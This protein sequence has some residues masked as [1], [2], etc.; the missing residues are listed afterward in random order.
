MARAGIEDY[1]RQH[2]FVEVTPEIMSE[3]RGEM[4]M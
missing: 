2:G 1:A 3:A 4:G